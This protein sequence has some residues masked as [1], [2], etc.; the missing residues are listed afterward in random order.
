MQLVSNPS[1]VVLLRVLCLYGMRGTGFLRSRTILLECAFPVVDLS[2]PPATKRCSV[3]YGET[4][5]MSVNLRTPMARHSGGAITSYNTK[6]AIC[7]I[8]V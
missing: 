2:C 4:P 5:Y 8:A 3:H 1:T 6:T 7:I